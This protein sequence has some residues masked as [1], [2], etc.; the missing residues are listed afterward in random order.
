[1]VEQPTSMLLNTFTLQN[2]VVIPSPCPITNLK[3][4]SG[5]PRRVLAGPRQ[6]TMPSTMLQFNS[7]EDLF[8]VSVPRLWYCSFTS[9]HVA[10]DTQLLQA[11]TR[12]PYSQISVVKSS[13]LQL[14]GCSSST[15]T[16]QNEQKSRRDSICFNYRWG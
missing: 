7:T 4:S 12:P 15:C 13:T 3:P 16:S 8:P 1:M 11:Q 10:L 2:R 5:L 6:Q 14:P 9:V